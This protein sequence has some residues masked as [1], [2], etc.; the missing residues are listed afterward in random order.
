[1]GLTLSDIIWPSPLFFLSF[2]IQLSQGQCFPTYFE[3][4]P[5]FLFFCLDFK[6]K[7]SPTYFGAF[8]FFLQFFSVLMWL[9]ISEIIWPPP[10]FFY[11][12][13]SNYHKVNVL[14]HILTLPPLFYFFVWSSKLNFLRH[15]LGPSLTFYVWWFEIFLL[16]YHFLSNYHKVNLLRHILTLPLIF[17][18]FYCLV[19]KLVF[20]HFCHN[21]EHEFEK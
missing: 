10:F 14:R 13:L 4:S 5:F 3:P 19:I 7:F 2:F 6:I 17:F 8:P 1:M 20:N 18:N 15:I 21:I 16:S 11:H 9:M 12:S